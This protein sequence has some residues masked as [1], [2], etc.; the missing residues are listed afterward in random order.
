MRWRTERVRLE[1]P[2]TP[3]HRGRVVGFQVTSRTDEETPDWRRPVLLCGWA[4]VTVSAYF[5]LPLHAFGEHR[6][7]LSWLTLIT[8]LCLVAA[9]L[10][11]QIQ[12]VLTGR[13][14]TLPAWTVAGLM[15]LTVLLFS[16]AYYVLARQRGEF[17]GLSTRLDA[18]YFTIVTL[19]TVG[20]GD[21]S[22][23]G[24][25][26]RLV[27]LLQIVYSFVFLTA[28]ATVLSRQ[29]HARILRHGDR[30]PPGGQEE[31]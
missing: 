26:A 3:V 8:G 27:T 19:A 5:L 13:A 28:G 11:R 6:P 18:L 1:L 14:G 17:A 22:P 16:S 21:I 30:P 23:T 25:T 7:V 15:C 9:G 24:Q 20:Y 10:L 2:G 29:M 4:A 12:H 31:D